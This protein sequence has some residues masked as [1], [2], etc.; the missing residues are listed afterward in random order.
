MEK[1]APLTNASHFNSRSKVREHR[2]DLI[3]MTVKLVP[4]ILAVLLSAG[5][6]SPLLPPAGASTGSPAGTPPFV[7]TEWESPAYRG[8]TD[9]IINDTDRDG[10]PELIIWGDFE[11]ENGDPVGLVRVIRQPGYGLVWSADYPGAYIDVHLEDLY[12][13]GSIQMVVGQRYDDFCNIT[14][15]SGSDFR[16]IAQV[17]TLGGR[18]W[19]DEIRDL[20]ADGEPEFVLVNNTYR[21]DGATM[22]RFAETWLNIWGARSQRLKWT[23]P[24]PTGT[25]E[26]FGIAQLD[27]DPQSEIYL[28]TRPYEWDKAD[29]NDTICVFDGAA[30]RVQWSGWPGGG[31]E[32]P[33]LFARDDIGGTARGFLAM[34]EWGDYT[35]NSILSIDGGNGSI[36]WNFTRPRI[37]N[38]PIPAD[39]NDD[40]AKELLVKSAEILDS[41]NRTY[42]I[43]CY[44]LDRSDGSVEWSAGPFFGD[45]DHFIDFFPLY[46]VDQPTDVQGYAGER[47]LPMMVILHTSRG[48]S[49]LA[50]RFS[51]I[52]GR[53]FSTLRDFSN[54]SSNCIGGYRE[55]QAARSVSGNGTE[56]FVIETIRQDA[57]GKTYFQTGLHVY[58][59]ADFSKKWCMEGFTGDSGDLGF[60]YPSM[61]ISTMV[62]HTYNMSN[63]VNHH[64]FI[65]RGTHEVF[66]TSPRSWCDYSFGNLS[67]SDR[68]G[69]IVISAGDEGDDNGL[70]WANVTVLNETTF[71]P[72]WNMTIRRSKENT[73]YLEGEIL[74]ISD[75][76]H[77][78]RNE[79]VMG[80]NWYDE[81]KS[82]DRSNVTVLEFSDEPFSSPVLPP[83]D[84]IPA[85]LLG[86]RSGP[87][88]V[89]MTGVT[90]SIVVIGVVAL[91]YFRRRK[92]PIV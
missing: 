59:M 74:E 69:I 86:A 82:T 21:F 8:A 89:T 64:Y 16:A 34:S 49:D 83:T 10:I 9:T 4:V 62:L 40:G 37:Q 75:L 44:V 90:I 46:L 65:D 71:L 7:R 51:I 87:A 32:R 92:R 33:V 17:P 57:G 76:D 22:E 45:S 23:G 35:Q 56:L 24:V 79:L 12:G 63:S 11:D 72:E 81:I 60:P 70:C 38:Y 28:I 54:F 36:I 77:D 31:P 14:I 53:T 1:T 3:K 52:D 66:W 19:R 25:L 67:G 29:V 91:L 78:R 80:F 58:S 6:L 50:K 48:Q 13:N 43:T 30:G 2:T 55:V 85:P 41:V 39:I 47:N 27:A 18:L 15:F 42:N 20:D 26:D 61:P 73:N 88:L 84:H 68:N 5:S